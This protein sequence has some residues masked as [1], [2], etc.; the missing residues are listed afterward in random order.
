MCADTSGVDNSA[1]EVRFFIKVTKGTFKADHMPTACDEWT[2]YRT[3]NGYGQFRFQKTMQLAHRV[4]WFLKYGKW[5]EL[6]LL[7][8][9]DHP[10]CVN[11]EHLREGTDLDN[12]QDRMQRN[13]D[14]HRNMTEC[15]QGH[16]FNPD[17]TYTDPYG[18]RHCKECRKELSRQ[19]RLRKKAA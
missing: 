16:Q 2:A 9:C 17:N 1:L 13:R 4:A 12:A 3:K 15:D 6:H 10:P 8:A 11:T 5:P 14:G 18:W 7:H 19:Y